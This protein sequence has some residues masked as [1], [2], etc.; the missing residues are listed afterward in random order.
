MDTQEITACSRASGLPPR[1]AATKGCQMRLALQAKPHRL[2]ARTGAGTR[3]PHRIRVCRPERSGMPKRA[4]GAGSIKDYLRWRAGKEVGCVFARLMSRQPDRHGQRIVVVPG[5]QP[6][7]AAARVE[8]LVGGF[9]ADSSAA[10][11]TVLFPKVQ[12]LPSMVEIVLTLG[13]KSNWVVN[14]S[15][16]ANTGGGDVVAFAV[17]RKIP[18]VDGTPVPSEALVLGP[19]VEFP[20]TRRAPIAALEI[21]VGTPQARSPKDNKPTTKAHLAH[22][23]LSLPT[24]ETKQSMWKASERD[25]LA[26]LGGVEDARAKAKVAFTVPLALAQSIGCWP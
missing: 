10:A 24:P 17:S 11:A 3:L 22:V 1:L 9:V 6:A 8:E 18:L 13:S 14:R 20:A 21:F 26:S 23:D 15:F 12:D 16:L 7:R 2:V 4:A 25:R 19:F 5:Q